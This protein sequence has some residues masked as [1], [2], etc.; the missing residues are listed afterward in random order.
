MAVSPINLSD[1]DAGTGGFVLIGQV[2]GDR[3]GRSVASA[4]DINGDGFADLIVASYSAQSPNGTN[5]GRSYV[6]FGQATGFGATVDLTAVA[7]GTGGFVLN[8][9]NFYDGFGWSVASAGDIN[10]D[11]FHD[12]IVGALNADRPG[13]NYT[14]K[15]YVVFGKASGFPASIEAA[16]LNA[17][18]GG[19]AISGL[20]KFDSFGASVA[21][22]G[23]INGDGLDDLIIGAKDH[24]PA[25]GS[26]AGASY[27]IFGRSTGFGATVELNDVVAGTGGFV[28][29]GIDAGDG[30]GFSVASAGDINGDGLDDLI[31]GAPNANS[32]GV[33]ASGE[34][35]VV[36]GKATGFG[37]SIDLSAVAAGTGGFIINAQGAVDQ[38]GRSVSSAGD[39]NGDGIAD[40]VVGARSATT[41]GGTYAGKSYVV[42]G[43]AAGFGASV[44][45]ATVAAGTGG[46]VINGQAAGDN[47]GLSVAT[48]GDLN[49]DGFDDIVIGAGF[50]SLPSE[51]TAG[52]SYVVFGKA[53]GF[54]AS[55]DLSTIEAGIGGFVINGR[56]AADQSGQAVAAA[57]DVDGD[58]FDDLI[59]GAPGGDSNYA[60]ANVGKSYVVLGR[61]FTGT[62]THAGTNVSETLTGSAAADDMVGGLGDD[63]LD[64]KGGA[65]VLIGGGGNDRLKVAD[66]G[67][68]R[69]HGGAGI[70]TVV[71]DGG[72]ITL[73]LTTIADTRLQDIEG[74]D[75][76]GSGDNTLN[77][78]A[79]EVV[80]LST[81]SNTLRVD[82]DAGDTIAFVDDGWF[83]AGT[84][85]GYTTYVN[86]Q[87]TVLLNTAV[88]LPPIAISLADIA[89]GTGGFVINGAAADDR[90]GTSVAAAGDVNGDGFED[91]LVG[92]PF[93]D[94]G[95]TSNTGSAYVIFGSANGF[96]ASINLADLAAGTLGFVLNG[97]PENG[98][99]GFSGATAGDV[100]D[101]GF[102]DLI[103]GAPAVFAG[104]INTSGQSY[105]MFGSASGLTGTIS[106]S[107]IGA[108]TGGFALAG[109]AVGDGSGGSVASAGDINGDGF[110]DMLVGART[111][112]PTGKQFGGKTY[113]IFGKSGAFASTVALSDVAAGT[114][115]FVINGEEAFTYSGWSVASAGDLDGDGFDDIVI[116]A[117]RA[118][119]PTVGQVGKSYVVLGKASGFGA[120]VELGDIAGGTGGFAVVGQDSTD[121]SGASVASAGDVNGDGFN[122]VIIGA[123]F[124]S[125]GAVS[126]AGRSYVVFGTD[127]GFGASVQL[128]DIASG[129]GGFVIVGHAATEDSGW[130][131]SSA[132][133]IDGDGVDDLIIGAVSGN[134]AYVV[135][136]RSS[137]FGASVDLA[138]IEAGNGGFVLTGL[139]AN[140]Q[141]GFSVSAAGD[142]NGDG[143][144]DLVVGARYADPAGGANAGKSYVVFGKSFT[145]SV[146]HLGNAGSETLTGSAGANDMVGG[147]GDDILNGKGGADVLIGGAGNDRLAVSDLTFARVHGGTGTDTMALDGAGITLDLSAASNSRI[148]DIEA[149][150]ITG[151]GN[152]TL[153]LS[154]LEVLNLST[155]SNTVKV[156]GDAGDIIDLGPET[157]ADGGSSGGYTTYT[158]G[159]AKVLVDDEITIACF[160][161]GTSI[162]TALGPVAVE[163]LRI[164]D[165]VCLA[166]G[167]TRPIRWIGRRHLDLTRHPNAAAARPI[168]ISADA[169]ADGMPARDLLLSP[170]HAVFTD[171]VLIPVR[172]LVNGA[173]IAVDA[174]CS[175][176][177]YWHI[178]LDAHDVLLAEGLPAESYLD[179]GNRGVFENA[180]GPLTL[181][182]DLSGPAERVAG[183]VAPF[184]DTPE[185]V[186]PVWDW[187][188]ARART[189]GRPL[190]TRPTTSDPQPRI[191]TGGRVLLPVEIGPN[192]YVFALPPGCGAIHLV[193][194]ATA[195]SE[196]EPWR[197]DRR[198]LG[199]SMRRIRLREGRDVTELPLDHP[200]MKQGWWAVERDGHAIHRWTTG[201]AMLPLPAANGAIRLLEIEA[202]CLPA[203]LLP[204]TEALATTQAA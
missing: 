130:S 30:S 60:G 159:Q 109:E 56:F 6:I 11:G 198:M 201:A 138:D 48:A 180:P 65:D 167:G 95:G 27:V 9:E 199:L 142:L 165:R 84:S 132:G 92:A 25:G 85:G 112:T 3:A 43:K 37:A 154:S 126:R 144:D 137:G 40:L 191:I 122:D 148:Q 189:Q 173:T 97:A 146:S 20:A 79:R 77:L 26:G 15:S 150:D 117:P 41:A 69:L 202:G 166:S 50:A 81:T 179:T 72:A 161:S 188:A 83:R 98:D 23:D 45:L 91:L 17:G 190:P 139:G 31:I 32:S 127:A 75:L 61:D 158:F 114:G 181:H 120:S 33:A 108:G 182:P 103:I 54:G 44:N 71:L 105:V 192:R 53:G 204:D 8:G 119:T 124:A 187:L 131:V 174:A 100:N 194:R 99:A 4:G 193:S 186:K 164:G 157:W 51:S 147:L 129:T 195:P 19:F 151:A 38:E 5:A 93:A 107:D 153:I 89:A 196:I 68:A 34:S 116:G 160:T 64:G 113:L 82:G 115:G 58:G 128:A 136:G 36:F 62:V 16:D 178:E 141:T 76:G 90:A 145:L 200:D 10:G 177:T 152:N 18:I 203:Y 170:D 125:V 183:S 118:S 57:G 104:G 1:I 143:F 2:S 102:A 24:D 86:G 197:E 163:G 94:T 78:S 74:I 22:A 175:A 168:R 59:I 55:I 110:D 29:N 80:N 63:T 149:I 111:A 96:G 169:F 42:F 121:W 135:F 7:D 185:M 52:K 70:D 67:F 12:F 35:Y 155:T 13:I 46:F 73:D 106:L 47:S 39:I 171:G 21:S 101:D 14:G 140:D 134:K 156:D 66:L 123:Y 172:L 133:D 184:T 28:I 176:V 49:G 88:A 87:A 162:L